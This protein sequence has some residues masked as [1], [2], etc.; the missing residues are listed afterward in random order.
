MVD[1]SEGYMLAQKGHH[2][3]TGASHEGSAPRR[4]HRW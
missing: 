3:D 1:E 2:G 4:H